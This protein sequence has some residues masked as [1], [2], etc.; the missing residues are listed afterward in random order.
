MFEGGSGPAIVMGSTRKQT[1]G[2][3]E[4]D[5]SMAKAYCCLR[6]F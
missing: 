3:R 2:N 5:K 4:K 1:G 6:Y